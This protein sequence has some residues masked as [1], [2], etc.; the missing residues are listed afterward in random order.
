MILK[1]II[2]TI[3]TL[4]AALAVQAQVRF[5]SQS[6]DAVRQMAVQSGKLVFID[7]YAPWC[8]SC[9]RMQI[10]VFGRSDVGDFMNEW[11]VCARYDTDKSVG[12][13]LLDKYG[14]GKIP[15]YLIFDTNG[16]LLARITGASPTSEFIA[17]IQEVFTRLKIQ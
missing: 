2:L 11:F 13:A 7:L 3:A 15:L 1:R 8:A 5:T 14:A 9:R 12:S 10:E 6:T 17:N 4:T 16:N